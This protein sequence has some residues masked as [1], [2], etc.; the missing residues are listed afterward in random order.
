MPA[1]PNPNQNTVIDQVFNATSNAHVRLAMLLG[2]QL[3]G[4]SLGGPGSFGVGDQ[5]TS[6]GPFQIHLPAH[7]GV[8]AAQA[9][10]PTFAVKYMEPAYAAAAAQVPAS[11]WQTSPENA[12]EQT[13]FIAERPAQDYFASRGT[14]VVNDAYTK[15][16]A[17]LGAGFLLGTGT[18]AGSTNGL[19]LFGTNQSSPL[20]SL[21]GL[22]P[23]NWLSPIKTFLANGALI[24]FGL[25]AILVAVVILA[26]NATSSSSSSTPA[27]AP[28]PAPAAAEEDAMAGAE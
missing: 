23:A 3:E 22:D 11:L 20:A 10:D 1:K 13:A 4:G 24:L 2:A 7:P 14:N 6:F 9:S 18:P 28:A 26:H 5:G 27:A 25:V 21:S 16:K 19:G 8:S 12:A 17:A 15:A